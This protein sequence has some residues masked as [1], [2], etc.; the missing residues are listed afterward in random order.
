VSLRDSN[1]DFK[2]NSDSEYQLEHHCT[3]KVDG[4]VLSLP[5]SIWPTSV[6]VSHH[7]GHAAPQAGDFKLDSE[8]AG[9]TRTRR[10]NLNFMNFKLN[11][12]DPSHDVPLTVNLSLPDAILQFYFL[13]SFLLK[14]FD[15]L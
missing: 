4:P 6:R 8:L 5:S 9:G 10:S 7:D 14:Y 3:G 15:V 12:T 2:L 11:M 1:R 13:M